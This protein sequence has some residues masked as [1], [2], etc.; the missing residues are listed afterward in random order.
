MKK[1]ILPLLILLTAWQL[2][3][4]SF[5]NDSIRQMCVESAKNAYLHLPPPSRSTS[6]TS[7]TFQILHYL[8]SLNVTNY[9]GQMLSGSCQV[10]FQSKINGITQ[11]YLDLLLLDVDSVYQNEQ[12]VTFTYGDSLTLYINLL[13]PMQ[14]GDSAAV[15]VYY[16]GHPQADYTTFGGFYYDNSYTYN[17]GV[18]PDY[19]PHTMGRSWHP[20]IDN[21]VAR[22]TYDYH[23]TTQA[24][25]MAVC[26]GTFMDSVTNSNGT[27]TWHYYLPQT[28]PAYLAAMDIGNYTNV[29][30]TLNGMN[31]PTPV[32][33]TANAGDTSNMTRSMVHLPDAFAIF[34]QHYGPYRWNKI[35]YAAVPFS[36]IAMEHAT[37]ITMPVQILDGTTYYENLMAHELSHHWFGDLITPST[38]GDY[39]LKEG[40]AV[41]SEKLFYQAEYGQATYLQ[42]VAATHEIAVHFAHILDDG[43]LPVSPIPQQYTYGETVYDKGPDVAHVLSAYIGG[44]SA[45]YQCFQDLFRD[46]TFTSISSYQFRDYLSNCSGID[47]TNY[48][49]DW[50]FSPGFPQFSIDS[51]TVVPLSSSNYTVTVY[52]RQKLDHAPNYY[53]GV[54]IEVTYMDTDLTSVTQ[55][56]TL[57]GSCTVYQTTLPFAPVYAC[58]DLAQKLQDAIT[59]DYDTITTTGTYTYTYG[60]MTVNVDSVTGPS[61]LRIEHNYVPPDTMKTKIPGLHLSQERYWRVDGV[62]PQGFDAS[63]VIGYN[64]QAPTPPSANGDYYL[65]TWLITNS[66]DS[67][68]VM[69]RPNV[70]TDWTIDTAT[71]L[72]TG[73]SVTDKIGSFTINHLHKGEYTFALY[74]SDKVDSVIITPPAD[75][76]FVSAEVTGV[77]NI[78]LNSGNFIVY[79]NPAH[80][81]FTLEGALQTNG[82]MQLYDLN[83]QLIFNQNL[84]SGPVHELVN[85]SNYGGGIYLLR[86]MD[87]SG[88]QLS[89]KKVVILED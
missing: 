8:V 81:N 49:N 42:E 67:L 21:F 6:S 79:P 52:L 74:Q 17:L 33:L 7:D 3:A 82:Q 10:Q 87:D 12:P 51:F 86:I 53:Q 35:G 34:E 72:N 60:K 14:A 36:N 59:E 23:V 61:F 76:C 83:G 47:L 63:A 32:T 78:A 25:R 38:V 46:S 22:G 75:T 19:Y 56:I 15:T 2:N 27:I 11:L 69:Y 43:Y 16:H 62:L 65:D 9:A 39:W 80:N 28:I 84:A 40:W 24:G 66:E 88:Q 73:A 30:W 58:T 68:V 89:S 57:N 44:D 64:G 54:P 13:S 71:I 70:G 50:I 5:Y 18:S 45:M 77:R 48:F 26:N 20:C 37:N 41:F 4:Q 31:G 85:T 55:Q 1:F 29:N